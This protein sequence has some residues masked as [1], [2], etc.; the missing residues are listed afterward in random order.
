MEKKK[1]DEITSIRYVGI[2]PSFKMYYNMSL[3]AGGLL[4]L[5]HLV[6]KDIKGFL[7]HY[8]MM[9][10]SVVILAFLVLIGVII[11]VNFGPLLFLFGFLGAIAFTAVCVSWWVAV[12]VTFYHYI[13]DDYFEAIKNKKSW[14]FINRMLLIVPKAGTEVVQNNNPIL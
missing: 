13:D 6:L 10:G 1:I 8:A 11:D 9:L 12:F 7:W 2:E 14:P 3:A 4:G 5:H